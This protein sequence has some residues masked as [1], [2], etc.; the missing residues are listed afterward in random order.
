MESGSI[1][2]GEGARREA[3]KSRLRAALLDRADGGSF[4]DLRIEEITAACGLSRSGFYF[5]Y[6]GKTELLRDTTERIADELFVV[7]DRWFSGNGTHPTALVREV[8]LANAKAWAE[9]AGI[10]RMV[11]EAA[12]YDPE[13]SEFWRSL[14]D[15]FI[16]GV[17]DRVRADQATGVAS[18]DLDPERAAKVLVYATETYLH[19][20]VACDGGSP[21]DAVTAL[22]PVWI[23]TLYPTA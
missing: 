11:I 16:A 23:R 10:L 6:P 22:A 19:R 1:G 8:L 15:R 3:V 18:G 13:I 7:A 5:Y 20:C 21:D 14:L 17:A 12:A 9:H 4:A 2:E